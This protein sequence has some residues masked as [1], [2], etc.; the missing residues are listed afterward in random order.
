MLDWRFCVYA[1]VRKTKWLN[2]VTYSVETSSRFFGDFACSYSFRA[3]WIIRLQTSMYL[4]I[5]S[6][7]RPV[8]KRTAKLETPA[9]LSGAPEAIGEGWT[10]CLIF[11][12]R[13]KNTVRLLML[14]IG[15]HFLMR[16]V[17]WKRLL[18]SCCKPYKE[19]LSLGA[20]SP[21]CHL[22]DTRI[23]T[24]IFNISRCSKVE[25][26]HAGGWCGEYHH[27]LIQRD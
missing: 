19:I 5:R 10:S 9:I 15:V 3:T 21:F 11:Q 27:Y 22:P 25:V 7:Q 23:I 20:F 12:G 17:K 13:Q 14:M 24:H 4:L 6:Q 26:S 18:R 16:N 2:F 8:R 1:E